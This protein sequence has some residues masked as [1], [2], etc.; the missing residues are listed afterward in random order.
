MP[1]VSVIMPA[2]NVEQYLPAAAYSALHQSFGD[3]EVLIANDGS[4]DRTGEIAEEIRSRHPDRV[5]VVHLENAGP[6]TARDA[7][8]AVSSGEFFALLDSDDVWDPD[9]LARQMAIFA[10]NP[11][12]SLVTGN[13]R[14]LGGPTHG[15][16]VR[17]WPD[18]RPPITLRTIITDEA[19][20]FVMTVFRRRVVDAIGPFDFKLRGNEDFDYWLRAT[21]AGFTFARNA[22]PLAWYRRRDDSLSANA[23]GMLRGAIA[24]CRKH[25][26]SLASTPE[27]DLMQRQIA[28]YSAELDAA[29]A[30]YALSTRDPALVAKALAALRESRPSPRTI[31]AA[32]LARHA[33]PLLISLYHLRRR[34]RDGSVRAAGRPA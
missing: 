31:A 20:V 33:G 26:P 25:L 30:R 18:S 17:P 8:M 9:F 4:T 22:R 21:M 5:R 28:N 2:Y 13:G 1:A 6:A 32:L 27:F 14:Y 23:V 7:A 16:P 10:R 29:T 24:V 34:M 11:T 3:L 15:R 19:A 12:I